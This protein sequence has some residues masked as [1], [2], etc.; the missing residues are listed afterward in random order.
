M[1]ARLMVASAVGLWLS[2]VIVGV[3][4]LVGLLPLRGFLFGYV[5]LLVLSFALFSLGLCCNQGLA[6]TP[7]LLRMARY[8]ILALATGV[9]CVLSAPAVFQFVS[10][11][12][13]LL[14]CSTLSFVQGYCQMRA[15]P[16]WHLMWFSAGLPLGMWV[17]G[18]WVRR[19]R[20]GNAVPANGSKA[21]PTMP[22]GT[23][24]TLASHRRQFPFRRRPLW[25][26]VLLCAVL[27]GWSAVMMQRT[28]NPP[29]VLSTTLLDS[30]DFD[31]A[32]A[33]AT[34]FLIL[35]DDSL[36]AFS[37]SGVHL[38]QKDAPWCKWAKPFG[39]EVVPIFNRPAPVVMQNAIAVLNCKAWKLSLNTYDFQGNLLATV[40]ALPY[41]M[42]RLCGTLRLARTGNGLA[43]GFLLY[44]KPHL[45]DL[46]KGLLVFDT[47]LHKLGTYD[48]WGDSLCCS[49]DGVI[50]ARDGNKWTRISPEGRMSPLPTAVS[51]SDLES[52]IGG[53]IILYSQGVRRVWKPSMPDAVTILEY[54][55]DWLGEVIPCPK[56]RYVVR[57]WPENKQKFLCCNSQGKTVWEHPLTL[58]CYF[59]PPHP[60]CDTHGMVYL[61]DTVPGLN[62]RTNNVVLRCLRPSGETAWELPVDQTP[63]QPVFDSYLSPKG[64]HVLLVRRPRLVNEPLSHKVKLT[65]V[66]TGSGGTE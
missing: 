60:L 40:Q 56:S 17:L 3:V 7:K 65:F 47:N 59:W 48:G 9:L 51:R 28:E 44:T 54:R 30:D 64:S 10:W 1:M 39:T 26:V 61:M 4:L 46:D 27:G 57:V 62:I 31:G 21:K 38:W 18:A 50:Y 16:L 43:F 53:E 29:R 42:E 6:L 19:T 63:D 25:L 12:L 32:A 45:R 20:R 34:K 13:P 52:G 37:S 49:D 23:G 5:G 58:S 55:Q 41:N 15:T 24:D 22:Q 36:H 8:V 33:N 66:A 11:T 14:G 2:S 35:A